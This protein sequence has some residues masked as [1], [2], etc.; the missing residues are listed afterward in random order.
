M[1]RWQ[2]ALGFLVG[3][4]DISSAFDLLDFMEEVS[5]YEDRG[6]VHVDRIVSLYSQGFFCWWYAI[7]NLVP[8]YRAR[9]K[10][11]LLYKGIETLVGRMHRACS[12]DAP[13]WTLPPSDQLMREFFIDE[14]SS[15]RTATRWLDAIDREMLNQ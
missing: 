15:V 1:A 8:P 14:V 3:K 9:M 10:D 2:V 7:Y 5:I 11:P 4:I 12:Y 6:F 13:E